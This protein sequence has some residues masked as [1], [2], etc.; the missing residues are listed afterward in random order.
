MDPELASRPGFE[1]CRQVTGYDQLLHDDLAQ[2]SFFQGMKT[3]S[4]QNYMHRRLDIGIF[5]SLEDDDE[6]DIIH[7]AGIKYHQ[8]RESSSKTTKYL[9]H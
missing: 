2:V 8:T 4:W 9:H 5:L 6:I 3:D 1:G 7:F